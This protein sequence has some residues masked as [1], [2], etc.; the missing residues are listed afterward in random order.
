MRGF[1]FTSGRLLLEG[2][3]RIRP[4]VAVGQIRHPQLR[5]VKPY[6][7]GAVAARPDFLRG[8]NQPLV[9]E[10]HPIKGVQAHLIPLPII[11]QLSCGVEVIYGP[12][13][14]WDIAV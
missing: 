10:N 8:G 2:P 13:F 11:L 7:E 3:L 12:A 1:R 6:V 14:A 5:Q 9:V 4:D